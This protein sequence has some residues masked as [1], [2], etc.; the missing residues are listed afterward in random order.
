[1]V[2]GP[3]RCFEATCYPYLER[4]LGS[5]RCFEATCYSNLE[6][7]LGSRRCFEATCYP[8][9]E[10]ALG[11]RRCFK[12]T[13]CTNLPMLRSV[14]SWK[15]GECVDRNVGIRLPIDAAS[16]NRRSESSTR[17]LRKLV[18]CDCKLAREKSWGDLV[19]FQWGLLQEHYRGGGFCFISWF[20]LC[21]KRWQ[22]YH[23]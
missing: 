21:V 11:P 2:L 17:R 20:V 3:R 15:W 6:R 13:C 10:R 22:K 5:R 16:R 8:H 7:V 18:C 4:A 9:L 23:E 14:C 1:M 12:T 19:K